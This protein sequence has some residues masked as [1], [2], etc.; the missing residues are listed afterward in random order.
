[1]RS[2]AF[3]QPLEILMNWYSC[4]SSVDRVGPDELFVTL[5]QA[6]MRAFSHSHPRR[7]NAPSTGKPTAEL[8]GLLPSKDIFD[9]IDMT[10]NSALSGLGDRV[11]ARLAGAEQPLT[12]SLVICNAGLLNVDKLT[13]EG[14][15]DYTSIGQQ[16]QVSSCD[17]R[18]Y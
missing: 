8:S 10:D 1:L 14:G 18:G 2:I 16:M 17:C 4:G 3:D 7:H 12:L 15:L 11:R 13:N 5:R 6:L 9:G